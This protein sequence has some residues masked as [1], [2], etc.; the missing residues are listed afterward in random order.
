LVLCKTSF[1]YLNE[2]SAEGPSTEKLSKTQE[3]P[4]GKPASQYQVIWSGCAHSDPSKIDSA[5]F[6]D[7]TMVD[8]WGVHLRE[9]TMHMDEVA[10]PVLCEVK[11]RGGGWRR[12][13]AGGSG[14]GKPVPS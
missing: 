2:V 13:G 4:A 9:L 10:L 8:G 5:R 6:I 7:C 14:I 1:F 11:R 3:Q 12:L